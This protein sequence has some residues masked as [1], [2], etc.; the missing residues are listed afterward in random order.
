MKCKVVIS[1]LLVALGLFFSSLS[2]A[3][4]PCK[5]ECRK[6]LNKA[7]F[8]TVWNRTTC[9]PAVGTQPEILYAFDCT[10]GPYWIEPGDSL[11]LVC[12]KAARVV[13][14]T[15]LSVFGPPPCLWVTVV[16]DRSAPRYVWIYEVR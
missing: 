12:T 3:A 7:D 11:N 9:C 15:G 16:Y 5:N 1:A 14:S 6:G 13:S 2:L 4:P 10:G 8:I